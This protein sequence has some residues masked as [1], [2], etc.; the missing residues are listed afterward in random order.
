[1]ER[2][3]RPAAG[4]RARSPTAFCCVWARTSA[5][6]SA[7]AVSP[8][9]SVAEVTKEPDRMTGSLNVGPRVM[10]S[11]A[12]LAR[13]G[14]L[15]AGSRAAERFLFK[16]PPAIPIRPSA[17]R[18]AKAFSKTALIADYSRSPS[19]DRT[20]P[21]P[22]DHFS[23]PRQP[24]R[25]CHRRARRR[26]CNPGASAA[27]DGFDRRHEMPRREVGAGA[28]HLRAADRGSRPRRQPRRHRPRQSRADG[29]PRSASALFPDLDGAA[30]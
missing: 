29:V 7:S 2:S 26:H 16:V 24:D 30:L 4:Y 23:F 25:A 14:L 8:S 5:T 10:I 28:A 21:A 6:R 20:G 11:R 15:I 9:A 19:A 17:R 18:T 22:V 1:M 13:T 3:G 12:G 27:E